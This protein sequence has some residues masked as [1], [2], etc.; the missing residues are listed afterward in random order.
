MDMQNVR[1]QDETSG[2]SAEVLVGFGFNCHRFDV[3]QNGQPVPLL[4]SAPN[5]ASGEERA[6]GSGIPILFPFPGRIGNAEFEFEGRRYG[7]SEAAAP[8]DP[9]GNAIHGFVLNRPWRLIEQDKQRVVGEFQATVDAP[10]L[11]EVWPADFRL[12]MAYELQGTTLGCD[13]QVDNPSDRL[14]PF[15]FGTHPYFRLPLHAGGQAETCRITVPAESVWP[16]DAMLPTGRKQEVDAARDLR[17][18]KPFA[19]TQLDDVLADL[20]ASGGR[21]VARIDDPSDSSSLEITFDDSFRACVVYNPPHREAICIEPYSCVP[22]PFALAR[23][24]VDAGLH[25]LSPGDTWQARIEMR[26]R[27]TSG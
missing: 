18:G 23:R 20:A 24:G 6:S 7:L 2:A 3:V 8:R 19:Q 15:G 13:I 5:F 16:L 22:D 14:L 26:W 21:V 4:W 12:R 11:L 10:Q 1:L 25:V 27:G 9:L 17:Q